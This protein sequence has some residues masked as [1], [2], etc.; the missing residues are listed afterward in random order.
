M[1]WSVQFANQETKLLLENE[2]E[3]RTITV[4]M[5][6]SRLYINPDHIP[7]RLRATNYRIELNFEPSG[8]LFLYVPDRAGDM[9]WILARYDAIKFVANGP[10]QMFPQTLS[11]F[12]EFWNGTSEASI[13]LVTHLPDSVLVV[14][15]RGV[16]SAIPYKLQE[17]ASHYSKVKLSY[18]PCEQEVRALGSTIPHRPGHGI[19]LLCGQYESTTFVFAPQTIVYPTPT[20]LQT[21]L[22]QVFNFQTSGAGFAETFPELYEVASHYYDTLQI[23]MVAEILDK[24]IQRSGEKIAF[25][26]L[27]IPANTLSSWGVLALVL[28]Q[29]YLWLHLRTLNVRLSKNSQS[30]DIPWIGLY[31]DLWSRGASLFTISVLP[32]IVS[33]VLLW[34]GST[35]FLW[36]F[37]PAMGVLISLSSWRILWKV[38]KFPSDSITGSVETIFDKET[39]SVNAAES[40]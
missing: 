40:S 8:L 32:V 1:K 19:D 17:S 34:W 23:N 11:V 13:H 12:R 9:R 21:W 30:L 18:E 35:R 24:E 25:L 14:S 4:Q 29:F 7:G 31:S 3:L 37:L 10:Q 5:S 2:A 16:K 39:A 28:I 6:P 15:S 26:G 27:A 38:S 33:V 20:N 22:G 36:W